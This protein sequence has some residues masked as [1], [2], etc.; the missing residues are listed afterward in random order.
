MARPFYP[1][2]RDPVPILQ[3][4]EWA[5]ESNWTSSEHLAIH[6]NSFCSLSVLNPCFFLLIV[7]DFVFRPYCAAH[8]TQNIHAAAG[9]EPA[10][11]ES[12]RPQTL[13]LDRSAAGI[14]LR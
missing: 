12:D 5:P 4:A 14:G 3:E 2:E 6:Q 8:T 13:S 9:F 1:R 11:P 10:I 7:L